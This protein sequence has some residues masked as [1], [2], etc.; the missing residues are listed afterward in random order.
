MGK[1]YENFLKNTSHILIKLIKKKNF[2]K[3]ISLVKQFY[4]II[5]TPPNHHKN[6]ILRLIKILL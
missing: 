2:L 3:N 1:K 4:F 5:A 6:T